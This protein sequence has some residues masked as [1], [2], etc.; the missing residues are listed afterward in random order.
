MKS[1]PIQQKRPNNAY[2]DYTESAIE[3]SEKSQTYIVLLNYIF[4]SLCLMQL[5]AG[6][7]IRRLR[8][9][10]PQLNYPTFLKVCGT[11]QSKGNNINLTTHHL[12]NLIIS[13][14]VLA[15]LIS[16]QLNTLNRL[17]LICSVCF[18]MWKSNNEGGSYIAQC[19]A[20]I[21]ISEGS[22]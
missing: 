15:K 19:S 2:V 21:G 9:A 5:E 13:T 17:L 4:Y 1:S 3:I 12:T 8:S 18:R 10:A 14:P 22:S 11:S 7:F 6:P 16:N 20:P